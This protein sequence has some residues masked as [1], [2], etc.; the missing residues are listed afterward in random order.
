MLK[1]IKNSG[2]NLIKM[3]YGAIIHKLINSLRLSYQIGFVQGHFSF[4]EN[5]L[6]QIKQILNSDNDKDIIIRTY[7]HRM[8]S[9]IGSGHGISFAAGRMAFYCLLKSLNIGNGDEVI[10]PGFTC[11][12]MPN[13][14][15]RTGA[16]PIFADIDKDTFG[17]DAI[18]IEKKITSRTKVIVAQH[19]FGIPCNI[20]EI[21]KT[22]K[23]YGIFVVE[24]CAICFDSTIDGIKVGNWGDAAIFSTDHTKPLNTLIGGFLYTKHTDCYN[25]LKKEFEN[26]PDLS[27]GHQ[28]RLYKQILF[29]R[30]NYK[31]ENYPRMAIKNFIKSLLIKLRIKQ[32]EF[33]FLEDDY[34]K[35]VKQ[36]STGNNYPYPAKLPSFL[37]QIGIYELDYWDQE[38]KKRKALLKNYIKITE[39][40]GLNK[41]LPK[42]YYNPRLEIV[43]LRFVFE[44][45]D[46]EKLKAKMERYVDV[47]WTWFRNPI[48]CC[49]DGPE[50]LGYK[51]ESCKT[52][53]RAGKNIVNWPCVIPDKWHEKILCIYKKLI[54]SI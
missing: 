32:K 42:A 52:G 18:E 39:E 20:P 7:E 41:L 11:S 40:L 54:K 22:A 9:L 33:I 2:N 38:K 21:V 29:E 37:A 34:I 51:P 19:S 45:P 26:I 28:Q 4:T 53:E 36:L 48:I 14:V 16:V 8:A 50:S 30:E 15:W 13:A 35:S 12:V 46:A 25:K 47:G 49:P 6:E 5:E 31:P 3:K 43:P 24:D 44:H 23:K 10:L 27:E 17:S 1:S